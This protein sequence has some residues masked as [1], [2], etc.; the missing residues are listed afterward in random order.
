MNDNFPENGQVL[1]E[2]STDGLFIVSGKQDID[3]NSHFALTSHQSGEVVIV[4][5]QSLHTHFIESPF[6]DNFGTK[7]L[8]ENMTLD[9]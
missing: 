3:S 2:A 8:L 7:R 9:F 4:S 1:F 5:A 6:K